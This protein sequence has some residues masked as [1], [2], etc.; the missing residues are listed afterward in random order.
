MYNIQLVR[1]ITRMTRSNPF[2]DPNLP[3]WICNRC[4]MKNSNMRDKCVDCGQGI[5]DNG[6]V[7]I[8]RS[9]GRWTNG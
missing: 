4:S 3:I 2:S 1:N 6:T 8:R 5:K 7:V 9:G